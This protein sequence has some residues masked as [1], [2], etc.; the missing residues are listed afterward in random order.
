MFFDFKQLE[1]RNIEL[2]GTKAQLRVLTS[3]SSK[4]INSES[5]AS[6]T[7]NSQVS[8]PSMKAM[9]PLTLDEINSSSST[10]SATHDHGDREGANNR[11]V[12]KNR[13]SKIPLAG[14][15]MNF[16]P[17][18]PTGRNSVG[19]RSPSGPLSNRSLNKNSSSLNNRF[20][21]TSSTPKSSNTNTTT[22]QRPDS[23]LSV[24][25]DVSIS[26][27]YVRNN[28]SSIPVSTQKS[29]TVSYANKL[30]PVP[31]IKRESFSSKMRNMD[32]LSRLHT[33]T[34]PTHSS[35]STS[36]TTIH[37]SPNNMSPVHVSHDNNSSPYKLRDK[38]QINSQS[39]T[40]TPIRRMTHTSFG[41]KG[42]DLSAEPVEKVQTNLRKIWNMLKI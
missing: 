17:K 7:I 11:T 30:S 19:S 21:M 20:E 9:T 3:K 35:I 32:S 40:S 6:S 39:A 2:E 31:K 33:Y 37:G 22:Y 8:T 27:S 28:T 34:S 41:S 15:K 42:I 23:A 38:K 29:P 12:S 5:F 1:E 18:P 24:R 14:T 36:T 4:T 16:S 13:P 25:K 10:E 26:N